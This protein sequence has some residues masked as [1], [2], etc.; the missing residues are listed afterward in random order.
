MLDI[1]LSITHTAAVVAMLFLASQMWKSIK[2]DEQLYKDESQ[3]FDLAFRGHRGFEPVHGAPEDTILPVRGSDKAAGYDFY[4][5]NDI[6]VPAHGK[7]ELVFFNVKAYMEPDEFLYMRIRSGMAT[8]HEIMLE[9]SGV[10]DADYY[11]NPTTDGNIATVF[12]NNSNVSYTIKKGERC[13]QGIFI[14]Y[15]TVDDDNSLG[16]RRGGYGSTGK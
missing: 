7:S 4:A 6:L 10:I 14:K 5:P 2:R 16:A 3:F 13:C 12:R 8:K 15:L 11:G 9:T 1:I